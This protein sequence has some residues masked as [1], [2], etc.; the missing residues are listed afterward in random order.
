LL[1]KIPP[2]EDNLILQYF[3]ER[4]L[5][6]DMIKTDLKKSLVTPFKTLKVLELV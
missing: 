2:Q 5:P 6:L 4:I 1:I 3:K